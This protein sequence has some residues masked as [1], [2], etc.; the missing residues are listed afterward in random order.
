MRTPRFNLETARSPADQRGLRA[1][2]LVEVLVTMSIIV[3]VTGAMLAVHLCGLQ[4][5]E[6][7][8]VKLGASDD[9]RTA[10]G[11]LSSEIRSAKIIRI[12]EGTATSFTEAGQDQPQR[13]GAIQIYSSTNTNFYVRYYLDG[14]NLMRNVTNSTAVSTVAHS[15]SNNI[16]FTAEN[17][18]GQTLTSNQN[19]RVIAL[20]MQFYELQNPPIQIGVG[21]Y[22]DFYQLR[23]KMTRRTLE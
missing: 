22:Y 19:N 1:Y 16:V 18:R 17:F 2:T 23:T 12:G 7:T 14:D 10:L 13:G 9:A 20:S 6:L 4:M 11:K 15:I 8:K 21:K 5:F 3:L